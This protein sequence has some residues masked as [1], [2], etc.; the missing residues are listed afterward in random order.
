MANH[1]RTVTRADIAGGN[2]DCRFQILGARRDT[3]K[4]D[5]VRQFYLDVTF[6]RVHGE[7]TGL[8]LGHI[9]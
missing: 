5:A 2:R 3:Q 6:F 9:P 8:H 7:P 4:F 1:H